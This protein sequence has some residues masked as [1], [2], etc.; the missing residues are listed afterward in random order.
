[1]VLWEKLW[2]GKE[3]N[4]YEERQRK[5][6]EIIFRK[7][8]HPSNCPR[9]IFQSPVLLFPFIGGQYSFSETME[10][11]R[12]VA[13]ILLYRGKQSGFRKITV[14]EILSQVE[15]ATACS[16]YS[17]CTYLPFSMK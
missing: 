6:K 13:C 2:Q 16:Y 15:F 8:V 1:M 4:N 9:S 12:A 17:L 7:V 10:K 14:K 5:R 3:R 11:E